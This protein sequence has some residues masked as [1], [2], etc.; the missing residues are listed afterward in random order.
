MTQFAEKKVLPYS[1]QQLFDLVADVASY[2]EF[3][4]WIQSTK[5]SD[6]QNHG[7]HDSFIAD[8]IVGYKFITYP[9]KCRVHLYPPHRICIDYIDG[10]FESLINEWTF[11]PIT[12]KLTELSFFMEFQLK[13]GTLQALLQPLLDD[14]V[15]H[16]TSAFEKRAH[17][18]Y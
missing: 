18:L 4:P 17:A 11:Q 16:M 15:Q 9:Y 1:C 6:K 14:V 12:E 3:L 7:D 13:T 10:P 8:L 2:P 5:L